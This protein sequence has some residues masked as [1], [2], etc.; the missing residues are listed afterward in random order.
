MILTL[1]FWFLV[2]LIV[3]AYFGYPLLVYLLARFNPQSIEKGN[4][5]PKVSFITVAYNEE[6]C[7]KEKIEN[8]F[9]LDYPRNKLDIIFVSD[10]S[11]DSTNKIASEYSGRGIK[12]IKFDS[13]RGKA[14]CLNDAVSESD[15]EILVFSDANV[16]YEKGAI[17]K[18]VKNF[19]DNR[20]GG[21]TGE[22]HYYIDK[23]S[24]NEGEGLF[25]KYERFIRNC[26]SK[27]YSLIGVN[28]AMYAIRKELY[29]PIRED[30]VTDDFVIALNV[31][32]QGYKIAY[33]PEAKG[34]E[35]IY[36]SAKDEFIRKVRMIAGGYQALNEFKER[37]K[38][39][40]FPVVFELISHKLFRWLVPFFLVG[41]FI[42]NMFLLDL[43]VY[44]FFF[45]LQIFFYLV[46]LLG[47]IF[48]KRRIV[49]PL[50]YLYYFVAVNLAGI[51]GLFKFITG[52][53][54]VTW[55]RGR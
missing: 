50:S 15:G 53:Q 44:R 40:P 20:I 39:I 3:Y 25:A 49:S 16:I 43:T 35:K 18:L 30:I 21:V 54:K 5:T 42:V 9:S 13:R 1:L 27:F 34:I 48:E 6:D 46:V 33:E 17:K 10:G 36:S 45:I 29:I 47:Y 38:E 11:T 12:F 52:T 7:I 4:I 24:S 23:S 41:I 51:F 2:V 32:V 14:S 8:S 37:Y 26:E 22:V 31:I 55:S 19:E 28:G